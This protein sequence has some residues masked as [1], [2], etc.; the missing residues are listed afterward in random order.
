MFVF[1]VTIFFSQNK[2]IRKSEIPSELQS[3]CVLSGSDLG[4]KLF[5]FKSAYN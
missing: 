4:P 3:V 2:R 1:V 5:G